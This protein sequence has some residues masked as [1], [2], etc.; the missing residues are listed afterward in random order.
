MGLEFLVKGIYSCA[1]S[2][3][4][5]SHSDHG[6]A[7]VALV[8]MFTDCHQFLHLSSNLSGEHPIHYASE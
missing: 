6:G 3:R 4:F 2:G 5:A 1:C 8:P 7:D